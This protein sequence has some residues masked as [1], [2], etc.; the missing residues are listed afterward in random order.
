ML[1]IENTLGLKPNI[2]IAPGYSQIAAV[3]AKMD[4]VA[5]KLNGFAVVDVAAETVTAALEARATGN[6]CNGQRC[7]CVM[8]SRAIRYNSHEKGNQPC[9]LSVF[10]AAAKASR[11]AVMGYWVSPSNSEL[12]DIL[13][14]DVLIR[15]SLTDPAADTNLL[16]AKA[17][18]PFSVAPVRGIAFGVTGLQP[19]QPKLQP[20]L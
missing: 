12:T 19:S 2:L 17:L 11:D 10:W 8:F 7:H 14:T 13:S 18:L 5:I 1:D 4:S 6:L 20:M 9:A 16:N 3:L 15:S